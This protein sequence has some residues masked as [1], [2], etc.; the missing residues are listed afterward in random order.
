MKEDKRQ[1]VAEN[2]FA[3]V[4]LELD[5]DANGPR[6]RIISNRSGTE[7]ILD[8]IEL[9]V[10]S[11]VYGKDLIGLVEQLISKSD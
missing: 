5:K 11:R 9:D 7:T 4:T 3:S 8:P 1:I 6:I 10:I 2:E